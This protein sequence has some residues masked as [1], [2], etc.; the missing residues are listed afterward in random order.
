[1]KKDSLVDYFSYFAFKFSAWVFCR[2]PIGFALFLG[3]GL[4]R[5]MYILD[6]KHRAVAY[7]NIKKALG[8]KLSQQELK[9]IT[10]KFYL[11]FGQNIIE[12]FHIPLFNKGYMDKYIEVEG[13][14]YL[15]Q[16]FSKGRGVILL[17][18]HAGSWELSNIIWANLGFTFNLLI[19]E[20]KMPRLNQLINDYRQEKGCKLI[21]RKNTRQLIEALKNNE[22]VGMTADQGGVSG[23]LVKFFGK[24]ASMPTGAIKLALRYG[25]VILPGYYVRIRGA[26]RKII[27]EPPFELELTNDKEADMRN[28]LERLMLIFEKNIRKYPQEYLWTYKIWKYGKD[29]EVLI[30]NDGKAGHLRQS[31]A[32]AKIIREYCAQSAIDC[33]INTV[34]VEIKNKIA[35]AAL[36]LFSGRY[37]FQGC[38]G[39]L[40]KFLSPQSYL[41]LI[42]LRPDLVVSCGSGLAPVNYLV[43]RENLAKSA[44]I[45]R[46][47]LL[48]TKRF[49]LVIMPEHD[50]PAKRKNICV[51]EGALNLI[52]QG[53]LKEQAAQL[54]KSTEY[55]VPSTGAYIGLLIGG[56][57]KKFHLEKNE[58]L[59][60]IK[61]LKN[62]AEELKMD[63]L[64]STSRRTS[65]DIENLLKDE[66]KNDARCK[67]LIIANEKNYSSVVGGILGL[68]W[69]VVTSPES[70][71]MI[72]EAVN[73]QKYVLVFNAPGLSVKH[74][75]FLYNFDEKKYIFLTSADN[76]AERIKEIWLKKPMVNILKDD[77]VIKEAIKKLL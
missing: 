42:S 1:M 34:D 58:M 17:G 18:V 11:N 47:G 46:P 23:K 64:I 61:Q 35:L 76:F 56:D 60:V 66:F 69:L 33:R 12:V 55:R 71:S 2:L 7:A 4:G 53:Y 9:R 72:S 29:R 62:T 77:M 38:L 70:I 20:Q 8:D 15:A 21:E 74:Q 13:R 14:E 44:V 30:L 3:R 26:K 37:N 65:K 24:S 59:Q 73:S 52:D 22:A 50:H 27:I 68:S 41:A 36:S 54:I 32:V 40:K 57:S 25:A 39:C 6:L 75:Q 28:N 19:R 10:K 5:A 43:S 51:T 49:D 16:A 67:L 48:G 31:Q 63:L 45:L